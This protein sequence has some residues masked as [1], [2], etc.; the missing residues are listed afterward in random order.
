[1]WDL[2]LGRPQRTFG[3]HLEGIEAVAASP[4]GKRVLTG[5]LDQFARVFDVGA[6]QI[7]ASIRHDAAVVG[8]AFTPDSRFAVTASWDG[9]L[10]VWDVDGNR[11]ARSFSGHVGELRGLAVAPDGR[12]V[13]SAGEDGTVKVWSLE[14]V[15]PRATPSRDGEGPP[16]RRALALA[17]SPDRRAAV[18]G[19]ADGHLTIW[20]ARDSE[21]LATF[22]E[23]YA[24]RGLCD[25]AV[26]FQER[27]RAR[28][29]PA[30]ALTLAR[31]HLRHGD[32]TKARAPLETAMA[33]GEA[34]RTIYAS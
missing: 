21:A 2:G 17:I 5:S 10:R 15:V 8:V 26:D 3:G 7:L 31:C 11:L 19:H 12:F 18:T 6:G 34:P 9:L 20:D 14:G 23:W 28:G 24:F 4:D 27:S 13:L 33:L 16:D 32:T 22:G 29:R 1:M 25:I 30:S